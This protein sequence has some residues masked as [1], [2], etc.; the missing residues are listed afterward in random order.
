MAAA[1]I[2]DLQEVILISGNFRNAALARRDQVWLV[3]DLFYKLI[4]ALPQF[5]AET[6][7][8][9]SAQELAK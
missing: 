8:G 4:K 9:N 7:A 3:R 6:L 2:G 1:S 5:P